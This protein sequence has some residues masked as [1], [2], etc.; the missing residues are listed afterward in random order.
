MRFQGLTLADHDAG[1]LMSNFN[2]IGLAIGTFLKFGRDGFA[3]LEAVEEHGRGRG[4]EKVKGK[5]RGKI[6]LG[7]VVLV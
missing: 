3:A 1:D 6:I 2:Y 5:K 4:R 7:G